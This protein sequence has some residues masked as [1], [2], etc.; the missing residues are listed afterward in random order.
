MFKDFQ[1]FPLAFGDH[2]PGDRLLK[3]AD[4]FHGAWFSFQKRLPQHRIGLH[5][6]LIPIP[7]QG[8]EHRG[9]QPA[10]RIFPCTLCL[11]LST[12]RRLLRRLGLIF[13]GIN[14]F[15][16]QRI[17]ARLLGQK[18][19]CAHLRTQVIIKSVPPL[20]GQGTGSVH[21]REIDD[22]AERFIMCRRIAAA[23]GAESDSKRSLVGNILI[24]DL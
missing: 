3:S 24:A 5:L 14:E 7:F 20:M 19:L 23:P 4:L 8:T 15:L 1:P 13:H 6:R 17:A 2:P 18:T 12:G 21:L 10:R 11:R 9:I 16:E 22:L